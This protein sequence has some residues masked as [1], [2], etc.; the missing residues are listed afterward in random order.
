MLFNSLQF[1]VFFVVVYAVYLAL[2]RQGQ[3]RWLLAASYL[4][5]AAWDVRFLGLIV[6]STLI[7]YTVG[8]RIAATDDGQ[9]RKHWLSLSVACNLGILGYFKYAGFFA[10][11]FSDLL[12]SFD[13]EAEPWLLDTALPVGISF[14]TFQ[15]MSYAIDVYR[16]QLKPTR[17][18]AD[19]AL[20]V[21]FFPQ[22]VA[23]PIE[24]ASRL[25]PQ[26][27]SPRSPSVSGFGSGCWLILSGLV[28]KVV[29]ADNLA[30]LVD[31]IYSNP[32]QATGFEVVMA[33]WAFAW[34]IYCDFSGYSDI[35]RG[36]SRLM[37]FELMLNFKLPYL[38]TN[39]ADFWRRWHISL[40]TWLR[41]YLYI[42]LGG[43]R[44]AG[45]LTYRNLAI[46]MLLGGLWHGAAWTYVL[47]GA[48]Q[49]ALLI[50]HR[51]ARPLLS[52]ITPRGSFA[53]GLWWTV[54]VACMFQLICLGWMIFRADSVAQFVELLSRLTTS[55]ELG[56][57]LSWLP[58]LATFV[59][60]LAVYQVL[61]FAK[62]DDEL[63]LRWWGPLRTVVYVLLFYAMV[64][65]GEDHGA[66]FIYF[67]F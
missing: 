44:G 4:F 20:F 23:G 56:R 67:Q 59:L 33:T 34:Q 63:L 9:R 11:S 7:D 39:P 66:S 40:S 13:I 48:Y 30:H 28:K 6:A 65:L 61:Q 22:L 54:R 51:L 58:A 52:A 29:I 46:T 50:I 15:T 18:L 16:G 21:A 55:F 62:D 32:S 3:N 10:A 60:P 31:R 57:A 37:G 47:W 17:N 8:L 53:K 27:L 38:A 19:F 64:L 5:Y 43:N 12:G 14:Y 2:S 25:L 41:D 36:L 26:I 24:R 35:A 49:G 45:L 1:G 42:P